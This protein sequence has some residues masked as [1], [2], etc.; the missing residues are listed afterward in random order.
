MSDG[1]WGDDQSDEQKQDDS[2][3][4][5]KD[6][7]ILTLKAKS[8]RGNEFLIWAV[9]SLMS[10]GFITNPISEMEFFPEE[11]VFYISLVGILFIAIFIILSSIWVRLNKRWS[12]ITM[13]RDQISLQRFL[14][15]KIRLFSHKQIKFEVVDVVIMEEVYLDGPGEGSRGGYWDYRVELMDENNS[16]L[17]YFCLEND[18][19]EP[20]AVRLSERLGKKLIREK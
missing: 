2:I 17:A 14:P 9:I 15:F 8:S 1:W 11:Y 13:E 19:W 16:T 5:Q 10:S 7:G 20:F 12:R 18:A 6:A 3:T 4:P